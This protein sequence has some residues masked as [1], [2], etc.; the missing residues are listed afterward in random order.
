MGSEIKGGWPS[1]DTNFELISQKFCIYCFS[2]D[3]FTMKTKNVIF[4]ETVLQMNN[5]FA[6]KLPNISFLN[7]Y[8]YKD[9]C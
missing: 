5:N 7:S 3:D 8:W 2:K 9:N 6:C 4:D 1:G